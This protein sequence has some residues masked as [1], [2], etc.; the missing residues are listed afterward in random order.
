MLA[1]ILP[2]RLPAKSRCAEHAGAPVLA[3]EP[4]ANP[5]PGPAA[6]TLTAEVVHLAEHRLPGTFPWCPMIPYVGV[7]LLGAALTTAAVHVACNTA[8]ASGQMTAAAFEMWR[9][10]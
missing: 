2:F 7:I 10:S 5:S 3:Q 8:I 6:P 9:V 1:D 4:P